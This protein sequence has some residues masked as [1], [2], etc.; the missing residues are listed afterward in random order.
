MDKWEEDE[1]ESRIAELEDKI[2]DLDDTVEMLERE[3]EE[4]ERRILDLE[5]IINKVISELRE[6]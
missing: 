5:Y 3:K 6:A 4:A 2:D 1:Y